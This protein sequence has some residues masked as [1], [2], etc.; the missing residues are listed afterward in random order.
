[1]E[2]KERL[3][4]AFKYLRDRG[5]VHTQKDIATA[6]NA[7]PQNVSLAFSGNSRALTDRFITRFN[8]AFGDIFN[9]S[10][11]QYGEGEMLNTPTQPI[12]NEAPTTSMIDKLLEELSAQRHQIDRL[13]SIIE[14]M[15]Q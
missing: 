11:L 8:Q 4:A 1:M 6:M 3:M 12:A 15:Q 14:R 13:L 2:R 10:W 5:C 9:L 7:T